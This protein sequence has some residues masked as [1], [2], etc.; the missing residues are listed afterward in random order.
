VTIE[1]THLDGVATL[2]LRGEIDRSSASELQASLLELVA[3]S[4]VVLDLRDATRL[5]QMAMDSVLAAYRLRA[6]MGRPLTVLH[7]STEIVTPTE[8]RDRPAPAERRRPQVIRWLIG[9]GW[10]RS[11]A[12]TTVGLGVVVVHEYIEKAV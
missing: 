8:H 5:D 3:A 10:R 4:R 11:V 2:V 7:G 12:M 1:L 6:L 9:L